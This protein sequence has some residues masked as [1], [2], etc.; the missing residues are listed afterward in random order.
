M[1]DVALSE[2]TERLG[3]ELI[4]DGQ[5]RIDAIAP[6]ESATPSTIAFLSNPQYQKQLAPSRAGC[7]I[8]AP[9]FRDAAAARGAAIVTPDPYLYLARLTQWWAERSRPVEASGVHATAIVDAAAEVAADASIGPGAVVEAGASIGAGVL[10]GA[11]VYIGRDCRVGP[12][13]RL[14]PRVTLLHGHF[15]AHLISP[16]HPV[17]WNVQQRTRTNQATA[18]ALLHEAVP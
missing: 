16:V 9:A 12:A 2:I 1:A 4:G 18:R 13:T 14:G 10:V 15:K 3:G 8:V 17:R 5:L 6:L 7:V 11:H